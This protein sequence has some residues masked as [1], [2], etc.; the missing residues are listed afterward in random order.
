[1]KIALKINLKE[2][3]HS[4]VPIVIFFIFTSN[5]HI[6]AG[7]ILGYFYLAIVSFIYTRLKEASIFTYIILIFEVLFFTILVPFSY[8]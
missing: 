5:N 7:I 2:I 1:M 8:F 4:I 6:I 3:F